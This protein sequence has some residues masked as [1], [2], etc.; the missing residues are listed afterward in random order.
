MCNIRISR[1]EQLRELLRR[2]GY[3]NF[4]GR[5][6]QLGSELE[7]DRESLRAVFGEA[8][9]DGLSRKRFFGRY[10]LGPTWT[11]QMFDLDVRSHAFLSSDYRQSEDL[12][13]EQRGALRCYAPLPESL[14]RNQLLKNL[15]FFDLQLVPFAEFWANQAR[16]PLVVGLHLIRMRAFP[17]QPS[18]PSPSVPHQDGEPF[19]CIHL[20]D[21]VGVQGGVSQIFSNRP[22]NQVNHPGEL[23]AEFT[24]DEMLDTLVVWD[25]AVFHHVT[26][27][28]TQPTCTSGY[29]DVLIV[30]FSP[31]EECKFNSRGKIGIDAS[32]FQPWSVACAL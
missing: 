8:Q 10:L 30:D 13:P 22:L 5:E 25:K 6:L 20:I 31:L 18:V 32:S 3:C 1:I 29:R 16:S 19:T 17:G 4:K 26:P 21:R 2:E 11:P 27:V 23:Q 14:W 15:I 7:Q 28:E 24:L 12:N 9:D